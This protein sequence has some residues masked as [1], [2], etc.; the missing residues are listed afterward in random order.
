[1]GIPNYLWDYKE[2]TAADL[3]TKVQKFIEIMDIDLSAIQFIHL[4]ANPNGGYFKTFTRS[5]ENPLGSYVRHENAIYLIGRLKVGV[6][7]HEIMHYCFDVYEID[8]KAISEKYVEKYGNNALSNYAVVNMLEATK[9]KKF[10][11]DDNFESAKHALTQ[12]ALD[13]YFNHKWDE[14]LCEIVA[15]YGR[16]G[17]F[18]KIKELF[19]EN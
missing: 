8:A 7:I 6:I 12:D 17:Q 1:M 4:T 3:P 19:D 13:D 11:H 10:I 9:K 16:R 18:D 2:L 15:V 14:V 5:G